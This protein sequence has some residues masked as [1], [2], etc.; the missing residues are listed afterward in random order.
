VDPEGLFSKRPSPF[1]ETPSKIETLTTKAVL[2]NAKIVTF[3]ETSIKISEENETK[4]MGQIKRIA[5]E[6]DIYLSFSYGVFP[7]EGKGW[8][9]HA[10][11]NNKGEIE[12]DYS[13]RYL[14]GLGD[15]GET[16]IYK[17][18]PEVIQVT[19]TPYGRI[20]VL[21]CRDMEFPPHISDKQEK[22]T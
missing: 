18:G 8:N 9:K 11:I 12:I 3:Q 10:L 22:R 4:L 15:I 17:K 2:N 1:E 7:E 6:N 21:I 13:K 20:G 19:D 14:K 16:L 5:K